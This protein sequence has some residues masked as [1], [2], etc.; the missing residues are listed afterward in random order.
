MMMSQQYYHD[1]SQLHF[2]NSLMRGA[3]VTH[4]AT[5]NMLL[6]RAHVCSLV[7]ALPLAAPLPPETGTN[8]FSGMPARVARGTKARSGLE[9]TQ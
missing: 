9:P 8:H 1:E 6:Q 4:A 7:L 3:G 2:H 5:R